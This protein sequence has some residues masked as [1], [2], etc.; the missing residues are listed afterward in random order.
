[1]NE[2]TNTNYSRG[3]NPDPVGVYRVLKSGTKA[4]ARKSYTNNFY[5]VRVYKDG[6]AQPTSVCKTKTREEAEAA[7]LKYQPEWQGPI[8]FYDRTQS[9]YK[10]KLKNKLKTP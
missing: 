6:S 5:Y 2:F 1:M 9:C 8:P 10:K 3:Q 7:F 4:T